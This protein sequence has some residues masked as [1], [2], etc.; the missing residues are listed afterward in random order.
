MAT[1]PRARRWAT[2]LLPPA[3]ARVSSGAGGLPQAEHIRDQL[4]RPRSADAGQSDMGHQRVSRTP[5]SSSS[6]ARHLGADSLPDFAPA[7]P[8]GCRARQAGSCVCR[9]AGEHSR[10]TQ[11][12]K[13]FPSSLRSGP[14]LHDAM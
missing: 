14:G 10:K 1:A 5:S 13:A 4:H 7:V 3:A 8:P 12:S 11:A 2:T 6:S 9:A